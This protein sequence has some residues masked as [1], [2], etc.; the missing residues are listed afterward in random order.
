MKKKFFVLVVLILF[1]VAANFFE[2][3]IKNFF[4]SIS[5]K[6]QIAL[7]FTGESVFDFFE[8]FFRAQILQKEN[9]DLRA[10]IQELKTQIISLKNLKEENIFLRD[11]L[12]LKPAEGFE[13]LFADVVMKNITDDFILINKGAKNGLE[14]GMAVI[15]AEKV[16]VGKITSVYDGFSQVSLITNKAIGF[17]VDIQDRDCMAK[18]KGIGNAAFILDFIPREKEIFAGDR[19]SAAGQEAGL[20]KGLLVGEIIDIQKSDLSAYQQAN[21][22]PGFDIQELKRVFVVLDY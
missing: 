15:T 10:E 5:Q 6:S 13:L 8:M 7:A 1:F 16:L 14:E 11:A 2:K 20:P 21:L 3:E 17:A 19:V 18:T 22:R 9:Q 4:Y 12:D